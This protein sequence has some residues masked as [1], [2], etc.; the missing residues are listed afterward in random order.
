[1]AAEQFAV[2]AR[3]KGVSER[4]VLFHH[5]LRNAM[6]PNLTVIG[7]NLS[8]AI[9]GALLTETVFGWPGMGRLMY[10]AMFQR[11]YPLLMGVFTVTAILVVLGTIAVDLLYRV[12]DPRVE[13]W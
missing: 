1:V 8:L 3:A 5:I 11:D 10:E 2:T 13:L 6:L 7:L 4:R 9:S 12:F